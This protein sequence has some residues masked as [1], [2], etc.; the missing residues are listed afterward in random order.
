VHDGAAREVDVA[1]SETEGFTERR[2]PPPAPHPVGVD[3]IDDGGDDEA[4]KDE[5][6]KSPP[7]RH[8]AGGDG[9]RRVHEHHLEE[10]HGGDGGSVVGEREKEAARAEEPEV[11]TGDIDHEFSRQRRIAPE[12]RH[13]AD[14]AHLQTEADRPE[15]KDADGIDEKIHRHRVGDVLRAREARLDEREAR[16][17]EHDQKTGDERPNDVGG[18]RQIARLLRQIV[19]CGRGHFAS[20]LRLNAGFVSA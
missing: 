13:R 19:Q 4:V 17:H 7:L 1:V 2:K 9:G 15:A 14:A 6:R 12:R 18:Y 11:V 3:R 5:R 8:G 16:L 10:E 20:S